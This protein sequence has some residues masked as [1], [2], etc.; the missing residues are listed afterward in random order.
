MPTYL[1]YTRPGALTSGQRNDLAARLTAHHSRTTGAP[2]SFV[3]VI[4]RQLDA[5]DHYIGGMPAGERSVWV[6][7]LIRSGRTDEVNNRLLTGIRDHVREAAGVPEEL[8]WVY[9]AQLA[10]THMIEFGHILPTAGEEQ[11]WLDALPAQLHDRLMV[12]EQTSSG[13]TL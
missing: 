11:A 13:F 1:C 3:Q 9:L 7:G 12:F 4:F 2:A 10:P 8:V 6:Y 5:A